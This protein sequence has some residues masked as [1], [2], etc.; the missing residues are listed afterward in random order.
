MLIEN[1][2]RTYRVLDNK[3]KK[4]IYIYFNFNSFIKF[5]RNN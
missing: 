5:T 3:E 2:K 4:I 1:F